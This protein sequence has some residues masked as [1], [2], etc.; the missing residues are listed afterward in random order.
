MSASAPRPRRKV[1]EKQVLLTIMRGV[2]GLAIYVQN[3]RVA[4]NKPWG[5]GKVIAEWKVPTTRV[6]EALRRKP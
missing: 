4:G 6:R 3:Y 2:E 1:Q 5:G